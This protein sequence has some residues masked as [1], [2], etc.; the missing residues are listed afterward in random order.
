[1]LG[2]LLQISYVFWECYQM[3]LRYTAVHILDGLRN[4]ARLSAA[5]DLLDIG[6]LRTENEVNLG[7]NIFVTEGLKWQFDVGMRIHDKLAGEKH[8]FLTRTQ[9]VLS[10]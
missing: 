7:F 3:A 1:M 9:F 5:E 10:Y 8:D 2:G 6:K 4:D